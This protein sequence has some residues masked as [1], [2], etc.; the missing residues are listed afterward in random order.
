M[1]DDFEPKRELTYIF[2]IWC[3]SEGMED[4]AMVE[5]QLDLTLQEM[6]MDD[7]FAQALDESQAFTIQLLDNNPPKNG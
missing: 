3:A 2:K 1:S 5:Q 4:R 6:V 7:G